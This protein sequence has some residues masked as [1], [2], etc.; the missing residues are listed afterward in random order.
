MI[1]NIDSTF[2]WL[3]DFDALTIDVDISSVDYT[4]KTNAWVGKLAL[5]FQCKA[6]DCGDTWFGRLRWKIVSASMD[7]DMRWKGYDGDTVNSFSYF[8]GGFPGI[9]QNLYTC[10]CESY[11]GSMCFIT[12]LPVSTVDLIFSTSPLLE[13]FALTQEVFAWALDWCR[14][15]LEDTWLEGEETC[16]T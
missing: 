4:W 3:V 14:G 9:Y 13:L 7:Y 10:L 11:F 12:E 2:N 15:L 5:H 6:L 8:T 1:R 16:K